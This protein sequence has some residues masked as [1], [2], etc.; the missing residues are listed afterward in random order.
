MSK[1]SIVIWV[2]LTLIPAVAQTADSPVYKVGPEDVIGIIVARHPEFSG[3]YTIPSDGTLTVPG[4]GRIN[5]SG[6]TLEEIS[7]EITERM[8][9]RVR[10]PEI[11]V[12]LRGARMQR[13]YVLGAVETSGLYD[14]KPGW[15]I[16]EALAAAGGLASGVEAADCSARVLRAATGKRETFR[17]SDVLRGEAS[18]NTILGT[19]DV[20]TIEADE[21]VPVYVTGRVQNPGLYRLRKDS[22]GVIEAI[23]LA[24]GALDN[25]ALGK[26]SVA[27]IDGKNE[28][29]DL[30][31]AILDGK[32]APKVAV[33]P[34][35]MITVPEETSRIAVLGNVGQPG[36]YP[37]RENQKLTLTDAIGLARGIDSRNGK[38]SEIAVVRTENGKQQRLVFDL[39]KFLKS[40]DASQNPEMKPGDVVYVPRTSRVNWESVMQSLPFVGLFV[41]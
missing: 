20:I 3:D 5:A 17:L 22:A 23:T 36:F 25:A 18:A 10:D 37:M 7:G 19:G 35:D 1:I 30:A 31:G 13:V 4:A 38:S 24:G 6:K 8:K 26:V 33:R 27:H 9:G 32:P 2:L 12:T 11:T 16:T 21:T 28:T 15:R 29:V 34:A 41:N 14:L 40:G 39:G